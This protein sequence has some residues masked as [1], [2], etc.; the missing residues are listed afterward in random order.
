MSF[1]SAL[2]LT[3]LLASSLS[4]GCASSR[5]RHAPPDNSES[6]TGISGYIA[7]PVGLLM[8]S[9]DRDMDHVLTVTEVDAG[10]RI[11][12]TRLS[13]G[14][15]R[16]GALDYSDWAASAL[17]TSSALPTRVSFDT[18]LDGFI[19][20]AEF[21]AGFLAEFRALDVDGDNSL[22]RKELLTR[23]PDRGF[24]DRGS[25]PTGGDRRQPARGDRQ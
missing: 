5:P 22:T 20:E 19:T 17:G 23:L 9:F 15:I 2:F 8:V 3:V 11:E 25:G 13:A 24:G 18:D 6:R 14:N 12:W 10:T 7:Q 4:S 21:F 16:T 1:Q